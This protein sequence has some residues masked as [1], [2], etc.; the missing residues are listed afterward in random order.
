MNLYVIIDLAILIVPL[1]LS[2]DR[3]VAFYKKWPILFASIGVVSI[4]YIIWDVLVTK[5]GHWG[6]SEKYAGGGVLFDL[7]LGEILFFLTVPYA[8]IFIYEVVRAYFPNRIVMSEKAAIVLAVALI[9]VLSAAAILLSA[10]G[11]TMLALL[12]VALL[13]LGTVL[14]D[15]RMLR[16]SSTWLYLLLSYIPFLLGNGVLTALPVVVYSPTETLGIRAYTIPVEDFF[17]NFGLLSFYL[18]F[19]RLFERISVRTR[20]LRHA[21]A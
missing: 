5:A 12:S 14:F 16:E 8:C 6:F 11:Y 7:P 15:R 20:E 2:F 4:T 1:V 10:Y 18:L 3:R 13:F 19:Y 9:V 21:Q 17:Y